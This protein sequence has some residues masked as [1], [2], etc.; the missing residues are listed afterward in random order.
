VQPDGEF[1]GAAVGCGIGLSVRP[2]PQCGLNEALGLAVG[3][4]PLRFGAD[5]LEAQL[6]AGIAVVESLVATAVVG[7]DPGDGDAEA[8]V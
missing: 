2:F 6:R 5:V 1:I 4:G 3:F 8:S 7:H